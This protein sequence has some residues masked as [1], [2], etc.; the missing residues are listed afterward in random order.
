[1]WLMVAE[2]GV[3]VG[4]YDEIAKRLGNVSRHTVKNW[5]D[6]LETN[7]VVERKPKGKRVELRLT[8]DY[9]RVAAAPDVIH[10]ETTAVQHESPALLSLKKIIEGT[11][12]LGGQ[13]AL[14][15]SGCDFGGGRR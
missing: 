13:V 8:G 11:G 5:A 7:G 2:K 1:M 6:S 4:G 15:I 12:E 9:M 10:V 3:A 14:T